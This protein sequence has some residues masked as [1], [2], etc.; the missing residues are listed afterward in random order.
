M[1]K[2]EDGVT[3]PR[4]ECTCLL[5]KN[6]SNRKPTSGYVEGQ[7][8]QAVTVRAGAARFAA[9]AVAAAAAPAIARPAHVC[10]YVC[11]Y[12]CVKG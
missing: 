11:E 7:T 12:V 4:S 3:L 8:A 6:T 1:A 5:A 9:A 10:V 2:D